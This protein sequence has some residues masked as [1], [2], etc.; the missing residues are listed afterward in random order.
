[1]YIPLKH[2]AE[3]NQLVLNAHIHTLAA[4]AY[5]TIWAPV[6][7]LV[8]SEPI[9]H[10]RQIIAWLHCVEITHAANISPFDKFIKPLV[11]LNIAHL[12][13]DFV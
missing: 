12:V 2:V 10:N 4:Y 13:G 9:H 5:I 6:A 11:Q 8:H 3:F 1:M 7:A